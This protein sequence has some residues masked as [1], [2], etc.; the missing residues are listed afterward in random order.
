[1]AV[2]FFVFFSDVQNLPKPHSSAYVIFIKQGYFFLTKQ[3][4]LTHHI[5][6]YYFE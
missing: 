5:R 6:V 2:T 1:M 3:L 4:P